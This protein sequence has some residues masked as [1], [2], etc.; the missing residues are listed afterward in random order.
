MVVIRVFLWCLVSG[1][2]FAPLAGCGERSSAAA[3]YLQG[4]EIQ[5]ENEAQ[6]AE[7]RRGLT[8][9]L[10]K[11]ASELRQARYAAADG[12]PAR[13]DLV[14]LLRGHLVPAQ[15]T[16]LDAEALYADKD[17]PDVRAA[18]LQLMGRIDAAAARSTTIRRRGPHH[19]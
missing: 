12:E 18:V 2:F 5:V 3:A 15:A 10:D 17:R 4:A 1:L 11:P 14:Q 7:L 9:L 19:G 8:D 6:R 16:P 13:R